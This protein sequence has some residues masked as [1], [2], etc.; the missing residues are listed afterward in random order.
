MEPSLQSKDRLATRVE[1]MQDMLLKPAE[2]FDTRTSDLCGDAHVDHHTGKVNKA[3]AITSGENLTAVKTQ[4]EAMS[5]ATQSLEAI[6]AKL[7]KA[8]PGFKAV[9]AFPALKVGHPGDCGSAYAYLSGM[10]LLAVS[11][12]RPD[13]MR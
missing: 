9:S 12:H 7:V 1:G 11:R 5:K 10:D 2:E 6:V 8:N 4:S 13:R 3:E